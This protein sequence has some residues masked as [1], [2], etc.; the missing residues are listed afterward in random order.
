MFLQKKITNGAGS[1]E[2]ED[3]QP[4]RVLTQVRFAPFVHF[5]LTFGSLSGTHLRNLTRVQIW[6]RLGGEGASVCGECDASVSA[7]ASGVVVAVT[8]AEDGHTGLRAR[9]PRGNVWSGAY[10]EREGL[11]RSASKTQSGHMIQIREDLCGSLT[12]LSLFLD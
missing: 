3:G 12:G 8:V 7:G 6:W 4:S 5:W 10:I 9:R 2:D 11:A 1:G